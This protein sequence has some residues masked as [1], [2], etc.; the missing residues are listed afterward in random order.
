MSPTKLLC[1]LL[2]H[3][4]LAAFCVCA[5]VAQS[6]EEVICEINGSP[7]TR[8]DIEKSQ[9]D[10]LLQVRYQ[11]FVAEQKALD[12]FIENRLLQME[13]DAQHTSVD[14]L[15]EKEVTPKVK[16]PS[17]AE[18]QLF[19][20]GLNANQPLDDVRGKIADGIRQLRYAKA[21]AAY[22]DQLRTRSNVLVKLAP[23]RVD[24]TVGTAPRLGPA[25]APVQVIEFADYEC[26]YCAKVHPFLSKLRDE[27]GDKVS[28]Y[29]K[30][31]PLPMHSRARKAAEAARCAGAQGKFWEYHDVLFSKRQLEN[32]DLKNAARELKLD[33]T[34]FDECFNT[35]AQS[36]G[37]QKDLQ[38]ARQLGL[39]GTPSFFVNGRFISGAVDYT[40]LRDMVRQQ[41]NSSSA[42]ASGSGR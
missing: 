18:I 41:L 16:A 5:A 20:E 39:N 9:G 21:K 31:L 23:P 15:L 19:Y 22:L 42:R 28:I 11:L 35:G 2:L 34:K 36:S 32:D 29:F 24:V 12:Q 4:F 3:L 7:I 33:A 26:P 38:E 17:E 14:T 8:A 37:V 1:N 25:N 13:A 27:F 6:P 30:D 10:K 40:T